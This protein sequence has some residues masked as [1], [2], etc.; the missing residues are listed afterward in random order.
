M[1]YPKIR[2]DLNDREFVLFRDF[3][4]KHSGLH[5][6]EGK[7]DALRI[8][9]VARMS[10]LGLTDYEQYYERLVRGPDGEKEFRK[11]LNLIT[12]NETWFFR[13][14]AQFEALKRY[15]LPE[16]IG[17]RKDSRTIR[18]WSAGCSTGEEPYSIAMVVRDALPDLGRWKVEILGTDV[19]ER[20]L[21]D[22]RNGVYRPRSLR[23]LDEGYKR[24]FEE[25][26]GLFYLSEEVKK[27]VR[28]EYFN[29]ISEP[30]PLDRMKGWD[31]IFCRN[32]TIYFKLES[33]KRVI[34]NFYRSLDDQGY[35]FVG[36][37]E[38]LRF[39]TDEFRS[40]WLGDAWVYR[41]REIVEP[42]KVERPKPKPRFKEIEKSP[43]E[44]L[45]T[46][47]VLADTGKHEEALRL[48][49]EAL[50]RD[51]AYADAHFLM[52]LIYRAMGEL[53]RASKEFREVVLLRPDILARMYLGDIYRE[54]GLLNPAAREYEM[55][56][57]EFEKHRPEDLGRFGDGYP[58]ELVYRICRE[59]LREVKRAIV[60]RNRRGR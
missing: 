7:R 20:A 37:S 52:G 15:V 2:P 41:K 36:Y 35:L 39:L 8:A 56:L 40:V 30:Y 55:A 60:G 24:Y 14:R 16:I 26:E 45:R 46:A 9:L 47:E 13:D 27:M 59:K 25:R 21:E 32:V 38:N 23:E 10:A 5:F 22:A 12:V 42:A 4:E 57:R 3:I 17:R 28:F 33:T 31:I 53:G 44:L 58:P 19:S 54:G 1:R 50:R 18:I 48:C 34:H 6:G 51:P 43:D 29:L 11:L 49:G